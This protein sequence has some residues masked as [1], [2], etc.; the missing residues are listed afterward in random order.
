[1]RTFLSIVALI[2][3]A[4]SGCSVLPGKTPPTSI[5]T[6]PFRKQP[7]PQRPL[8]GGTISGLPEKELATINVL[9]P[10]GEIVLW[11][12]QGNGHWEFV[13]TATG[14]AEK[15]VMA[16]AE[17]YISA[18]ISYTIYLDNNASYLVENGQVTD[19]EATSLDFHF[20]PK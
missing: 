2:I 17:G 13:V 19:Q 10:P 1:M 5:P 4:L 7:E 12:R 16:E 8:I 14:G 3:I 15:V 11:G 6:Q 20:E 9:L 18:P